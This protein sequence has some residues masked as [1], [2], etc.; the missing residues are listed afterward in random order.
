MTN[1]QPK[2][3]GGSAWHLW[4]P[5]IHTP[6]TILSNQYGGDWEGYLCA[7]EEASKRPIALGITDY[8]TLRSYEKFLAYQ[9]EGRASNV[10]FVFANIEFRLNVQ[11][12][13]AQAVNIHL[14]ISPDAGIDRARAALATL[15][16]PHLRETYHCT[17]ESLRRLGRAFHRGQHENGNDISDENALKIGSEQFKVDW[18]KLVELR[19]QSEW[20]QK[21]FLIALSSGMDGLKGLRGDSSFAATEIDWANS[22]NF[23]LS[24]NAGVRK[25]F[26]GEDLA[27]RQRGIQPKPCL[28]GSDAHR[29]EKVLAPDL[30]RYC[31]IK[32]ELSFEGLKQTI[33]EPTRRVTIGA[34]PPPSPNPSNTIASVTFANANWLGVNGHT[35]PL[36]SGLVT[37]I[38]AR[39]SGKTAFADLI[40]IGA[41]VTDVANNKSSFVFKAGA[42]INGASITLLW[43]GGE[44][45]IETLPR[46]NN[47]WM[48]DDPRV[49]YLSQKFVEQL[50]NEDS[51]LLVKEIERVVFEST[52]Q[53]SRIGY[54]SF[55]ELRDARLAQ[56]TEQRALARTDI[57]DCTAR[58]AEETAIK[59][60]LESLKSTAVNSV[61][62]KSRIEK[63]LESLN[64][65]TATYS[66]SRAALAQ[67]HLAAST[68][69][70]ELGSRIQ[71]LQKRKDDLDNARRDLEQIERKYAEAVKQVRT[72]FPN[73]LDATTWD[74]L[75]PT[76]TSA[77]SL[78]SKLVVECEGQMATLRSAGTAQIAETVFDGQARG[79]GEL[80]II[81]DG[82]AAA[83]GED[84][85]R[86]RSIAA[87]QS[88]LVVSATELIAAQQ[89]ELHA[90]GASDRIK[91]AVVER[92]C[93]Y[94][95]L[96]KSYE[97]EENVLRELYQP[98]YD[99]IRSDHRLKNFGV[100]VRRTID[101]DTWLANGDAMFDNRSQ[102][103][104]YG[105]ADLQRA[106][107]QSGVADISR[108]MSMFL[109]TNAK[110]LSSSLKDGFNVGDLGEWL[111]SDG[112]F[113][114][115]YAIEFGGVSLDKLSPGTKG[116][117]LLML[118]LGLDRWDLRP[119]LIDQPEDNLDP[120][121]IFD[122]L[123]PFFRE[124]ATRRQVIM[125]T[126]NA[127]LVVN[128]D[129][130]QV[131]IA[132]STPVESSELPQ[133]S[134]M[135]G[136]L[137]DEEIRKN[138]CAILEG[139]EAAFQ[140]RAQRY[141]IKR[142]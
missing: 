71:I 51:S 58:I 77:R 133:I 124:V 15:S 37:I 132:Q 76:H 56:L 28:H 61:A 75:I 111:F 101:V 39:G 70:N 100:R 125:V 59:G 82:I 103:S 6:L 44:Q 135:A 90:S 74:E 127:N 14:L 83:M 116:I 46:Q 64:R 1:K 130:D 19:D 11:T 17:D 48:V 93:H 67:Q 40:A 60:R 117:V 120:R 91:T 139:G 105:S 72:K 31:W 8:Y 104:P 85:K 63:D 79:Y 134:Y 89:A 95:K 13:S 33:F 92:N 9:H 24:P 80:K 123:V 141:A 126:H 68:C 34:A 88:E 98:L 3:S 96:I 7:I 110:A 131:I 136:G 129:S 108:V 137:E 94:E 20:S 43:G 4:D 121:S 142:V 84:A 114:V 41:G 115:H 36:N 2:W 109:D 27:A 45:R 119:L 47:D 23:I 113:K 97:D 140:K 87:L 52:S 78:F 12:T 18:R 21:H 35:L 62:K 5:H 22:S 138:V 106:W 122:E 10:H 107:E 32:S 54:T 112:H 65:E 66:A 81:V 42:L 86:A 99:I 57:A 49:C 128:T 118:Y 69:L 29:I 50:C 38:G 26:S 73:L 16:C 55:Q 102:K 25:Y 30:D 53:E